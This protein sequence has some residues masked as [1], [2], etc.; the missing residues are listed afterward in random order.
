MLLSAATALVASLLVTTPL[1]WSHPAP[2]AILTVLASLVAG[3]GAIAGIVDRRYLPVVAVAG[4]VLGLANFAYSES[5][6]TVALHGAAGYLFFVAGLGPRVE[7]GMIVP[8]PA[9]EPAPEVVTPK[10]A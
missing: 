3:A 6:L 5:V 8:N 9:A 10:A 7:R 4:A 2:L 1:L